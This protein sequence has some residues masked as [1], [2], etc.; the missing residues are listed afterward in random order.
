[1]ILFGIIL[2]LAGGLRAQEPVEIE[3]SVSVY[4]SSLPALW[5]RSVRLVLTDQAPQRVCPQENRGFKTLGHKAA[6]KLAYELEASGAR[7]SVSETQTALRASWAAW[8]RHGAI[9]ALEGA[10]S[11][12][13]LSSVFAHD[14]RNSVSWQPLSPFSSD[15]LVAVQLLIDRE[16]G[17]LM[18]F[19]IALNAEVSWATGKGPLPALS[20]DVQSA[21]TTAFGFVLGLGEVRDSAACGSALY[22]FLRSGDRTRRILGEGDKEAIRKIY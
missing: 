8:A 19:D 16:K 20:Y 13:P 6:G 4:P 14:R 18:E 5:R 10:I 1:M 22:P 3:N 15:T 21:L 2:F 7:L 11:S 12:E 17:K 9:P